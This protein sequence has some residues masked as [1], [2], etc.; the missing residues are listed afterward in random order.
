MNKVDKKGFLFSLS[1]RNKL[2]VGFAAVLLIL[3]ATIFI[4]VYQINFTKKYSGNL[5]QSNIPSA[6]GTMKVGREV[7]ESMVYLSAWMLT[8]NPVFKERF[9]QTWLSINNVVTRMDDYAQS[10]HSKQTA[11]TW[12]ETKKT[13]FDLK[14]SQDK[15]FLSVNEADLNSLYVKEVLPLS[16]KVLSFLGSN[17]EVQEDRSIGLINEQVRILEKNTTNFIQDINILQLNQWAMLFVGIVLA[18]LI[19]ILTARSICNPLNKAISFAREI[20]SGKRDIKI[21]INQDDE[22]GELLSALAEMQK[23]IT[24]AENKIRLSEKDVQHLF[25]NLQERVSEY[26]Y[27]IEKIA[28]GDLTQ[29][30]KISGDDELSHLGSNLNTMTDAL[31]DVT[32]KIKEAID[33]MGGNLNQVEEA[34][35]AQAASAS[36][37]AAAV[38]ETVTIIDQIKA[39]SNQT[40]VKANALADA[41][42]KT[43]QEGEKGLAA[44]VQTSQGMRAIR[45]KVD[46]IAQ[47]ILA[48]TDQ[49]KKI[50]ETTAAVNDLA[51]RSKLLALNASIEAAKAGEAGKGFA[52]VATEIKDLAEQ[53]QHAT[54]QVQSILQ[55]IQQATE[56]AVM[57]TEEGNRGVVQGLHLVEQTG[58]TIKQLTEVINDTSISNHQI[59]AAV[60]QE[61]AGIE[62]IAQALS[63]INTAT[64]QFVNFTNQTSSVAKKF[65]GISAELQNTISSYKLVDKNNSRKGIH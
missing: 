61:A 28:S 20:A 62:Q 65:A 37:Q 40:L 46:A 50:S 14:K 11:F 24:D 7:N 51:E 17:Y 52:V 32:E 55:E 31:S 12:F 56:R 30:L 63:E 33:T 35:T 19:A 44:V 22:T 64:L 29:R 38:T 27:L 13:L 23:S 3:I 59:V 34:V 25:L 18:I 42:D 1:I 4:N 16:N 58:K 2:L 53:S 54:A 60:K 57:A 48:L 47:S 45:S 21:E 8:K 5:M 39:T 36:E 41:A 26:R 10:W 6:L 49:T 9:D 15:I 43:K